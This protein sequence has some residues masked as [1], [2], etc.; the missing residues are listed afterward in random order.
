V[1]A[2]KSAQV[3]RLLADSA[4]PLTPGSPLIEPWD[5]TS[6][7]VTFLWRG[8]A[9]RLA[10]W[11]SIDVPMSRVPET[12]LWVGSSVFPADLRT[13]YSFQRDGAHQAPRSSQG[14][15]PAFVDPLNRSQVH[16]PADPE[17]PDDREV[18]LSELALPD[19]PSEPWLRTPTRAGRVT[20]ST[21]WSSVLGRPKTVA[22]YRPYGVS[23]AGLPVLVV[24]DGFLSRTLLRMPDILDNLLFAGLIPPFVGLFVSNFDA[25]RDEELSPS[26]S[27]GAF[28]TAEL[29]PWARTEF[30]AGDERRNVVAGQSRGGLAA[31]YLGLHH[32]SSFGAV[33]AQ[34]GSFWWPTPDEGEP[35]W[36]IRSALR[37]PPS[38]VHF[39]LDVGTLETRLSVGGTPSQVF[40]N[41]ALRDT[42]R[43]CGYKVTYTEYTG[44]HDYINWRRTFADAMIAVTGVPSGSPAGHAAQKGTAGAGPAPESSRR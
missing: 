20:S 40:V 3:A 10:A 26:P 9:S 39:Y 31:A 2:V 43:D 37:Q 29:L 8:Q 16:F 18:F 19:A 5:A 44:G 6:R 41:R 38:D 35:G 22:V 27:L 25:T 36:M 28:V 13:T 30:G 32:P 42:L 21:L 33:I 1:V 17:D 24:F 23:T 14:D 34:S 15:G 11:W 12:D 7:L 4:D